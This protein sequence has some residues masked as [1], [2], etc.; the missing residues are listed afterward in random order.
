MKRVLMLALAVMCSASLWGQ[1]ITVTGGAGKVPGFTDRVYEGLPFTVSVSGLNGT[2]QRWAAGI[3]TVQGQSVYF[4]SSTSVS[5]VII[6]RAINGNTTALISVGATNGRGVTR[7]LTVVD[8]P[9]S[10]NA[11]V[12]FD[13][14]C[15]GGTVFASVTGATGATNYTWTVFGGTGSGTGGAF[16]KITNV[17]DF[18]SVQVT[19][20]GGVCDGEVLQVADAF[21]CNG[22][23]IP[24]SSSG[25]VIT[26]E[27]LN[28]IGERLSVYPNPSDKGFVNVRVPSGDE[29]FRIEVVTPSGQLM[30]SV[31]EDSGDFQLDVTGLPAGVY[32]LRVRGDVDYFQTGRLVVE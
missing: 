11:S 17:N 3:G 32:Y 15:F 27:E 18:V 10:C 6:D 14:E 5:N 2:P 26:P 23:L 16:R 19:V 12:Q 31:V 30:K 29:M 1:I 24:R 7:F 28:G 21:N 25:D 20:N 9:S 4:T 8:P 22:G 13:G